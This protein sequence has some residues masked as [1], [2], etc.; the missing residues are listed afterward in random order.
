MA[1]ASPSRSILRV[2]CGLTLP[3]LLAT[4]GI[5][6]VVVALLT[7]A[8]WGAFGYARKAVCTARL[9]T[10]YT[11]IMTYAADYNERLPLIHFTDVSRIAW[12]PLPD[13]TPDIPQP[14]VPPY[15]DCPEPPGWWNLRWVLRDYVSDPEVFFCPSH[16]EPLIGYRNH[17]REVW[18]SYMQ[19]SS[20]A[21]IRLREI[22][23]PLH[24]ATLV[25]CPGNVHFGRSLHLRADG[26][27]VPSRRMPTIVW[28]MPWSDA[29][30]QVI[31]PD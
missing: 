7:P 16:P 13:G 22:P 20:M 21:G 19:N 17:P 23:W 3:E 18:M 27:V 12:P 1:S 6:V 5:I 25:G 14:P 28:R 10:L 31:G 2:R 4:V 9:H 8:L 11:A 30:E 29:L 26:S 24:E 15:P